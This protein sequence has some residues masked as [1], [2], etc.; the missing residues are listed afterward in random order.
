M[1]AERPFLP[2]PDPLPEAPKPDGSSKRTLVLWIVLIAMFLGVWTF[3]SPESPA[4]PSSPPEPSGYGGWWIG[5]LPL[6]V[7]LVGAWMFLRSLRQ[8]TGFNRRIEEGRRA[9]AERRLEDAAAHYEALA[10]AEEKQPLH[11]SLARLYVGSAKLAAGRL[12]EALAV[13]TEIERRRASP[14]SGAVCVEGAVLRGRRYALLGQLE[15]AEAWTAEVR[16]R[17]TK[18]HDDRLVTASS[19]CF[20]EALI[21]LR[22]GKS[23]E[24]I[25][26]LERNWITMREVLSAN[27]MRA[28]E[29]VRAFAESGGVLREQNAVTD[30]LVR[31]EPV[32]AGEFAYLGVS[33]PEMDVFLRAHGLA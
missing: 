18:N 6:V 28:V 23:A 21:A 13:Y 15:P 16:Q 29:V 7:L 11:A 27:Q 4:P 26:L 17:L 33:W 8:S 30:R 2:E 20:T 25:E 10:A 3:L 14:F 12:E 32:Q 5:L 31:V 1:N 9:L 24:A 22:R 19:L